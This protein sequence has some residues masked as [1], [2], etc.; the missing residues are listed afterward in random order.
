MKIWLTIIALLTGLGVGVGIASALN[1]PELGETDGDA[2]AAVPQSCLDAIAA[3]RDRLLLNPEV[4]ET[5]RDYQEL[6]REIGNEVS[7]LRIPNLR[8]SLAEFNDINER[9][10]ALIDRS[11]NARFAEE[12][13]QCERIAAER[14]PAS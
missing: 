5:L 13:N 6:G 12:A 4:M 8:E 3:A 7:G 2:V 1:D 9:S 11:V 14:N 10:G